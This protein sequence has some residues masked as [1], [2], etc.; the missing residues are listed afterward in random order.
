[1]QISRRR[2]P[3]FGTGRF[4]Y[5]ATYAV[6]RSR[7]NDG[8]SAGNSIFQWKYAAIRRAHA[9]ISRSARSSIHFQLRS[10]NEVLQVHTG[11]VK[12]S[13]FAYTM[14]TR[15]VC[16]RRCSRCRRDRRIEL[17]STAIAGVLFRSTYRRTANLF[18]GA[19]EN[20]IAVIAFN[21]ELG[22]GWETRYLNLHI[23]LRRMNSVRAR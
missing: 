1:M 9:L 23:A 4:R 5:F 2:S 6:E 16:T 22:A 3:P 14:Y 19:T 12:A 10:R 18:S 17:E 13:A 21:H 15:I 11:Y 20:A 8:S 7:G